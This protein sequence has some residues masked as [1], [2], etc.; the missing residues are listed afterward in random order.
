MVNSS[1]RVVQ[2]TGVNGD[3]TGPA[4]TMNTMRYVIPADG[5]RLPRFP[6]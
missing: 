2:P 5:K 3:Y 4:M 6:D 1:T